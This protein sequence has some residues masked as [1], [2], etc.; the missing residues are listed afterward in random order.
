[1]TVVHQSNV[2]GAA[3]YFFNKLMKQKNKAHLQSYIVI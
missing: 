2:M 3:K 1:M